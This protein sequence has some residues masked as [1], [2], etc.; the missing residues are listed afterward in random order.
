MR[1]LF[2]EAAFLPAGWAREVRIALDAHG[3]IEAVE[4]DATPRGAERLPGPVLPAIANLH[5]H[6]FQRAMAG[7]C[8]RAGPGGDDFWSWRE[9]MYRLAARIGPDEL[10]AVAAQLYLEMLEAGYAAVAEF[11][12]LHRDPQGRPYADRAEL[13][14]RHLRAARRVGIA[15]TLLPVLY[16]RGGFDDRPLQ[17][18]QRRFR[19]D[20]REVLEIAEACA[21]E[22]GARAGIAITL[23]PVL[24]LRGG[25][26]DRPLQGA[27]RRFRADPREV[28]E[29]AEACTGEPGARAGI[30]IHSLRAAPR[31]AIAELVA[32]APPELPRHIHIAEQRL[33]V[34]E[35]I[36]HTGMPPVRWLL[37]HFA[38]DDRW[39]LVHATHASTAELARVAAAG[40]I[41]GLCPTTEANLGDGIFL[42]PDLRAAHGRFGVGSD[43]QV[44]VDPALEL[45]LLEYGQRLRLLRRTVAAA[46][47]ESVGEVL[48]RQAAAAG[49]QACGRPAGA[50]APGR[51]AD[52]LVL[53]A[54]H[55]AL[56]GHG[57]ETLLDA[58][59]FCAGKAAVR[60]VRVAGRRVVRDGRHPLREEIGEAFR[61]ALSRL[62]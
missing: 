34:E 3:R 5:S 16:L 43:S 15:I 19:A 31:Q 38:L 1:A 23:L 20:P 7:R 50:I 58:Y 44:T 52:L 2:A 24:Y 36:A 26:D 48:W 28:L 30:A 60:E 57:P 17:G 56:V 11:H 35:C 27:Q 40:A 14:R 53:D 39:T 41:I 8:E 18:A 54:D 59:L 13:A 22:P 4:S 49:A 12:Y 25:F 42:L 55:P 37:D 9:T 21:G 61:S 10:E 33:E 29:I 62:S 45:R 47:G 6:A 46:A 51:F 32:A